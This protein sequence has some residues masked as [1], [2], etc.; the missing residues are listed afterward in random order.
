MRVCGMHSTALYRIFDIRKNVQ[1]SI[2]NVVSCSSVGNLFRA[3]S[4]FVGT[5]DKD[6]KLTS[7]AD[8]SSTVRE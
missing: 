8:V 1:C 6:D 3:L 5:S 2:E 7:I 4:T